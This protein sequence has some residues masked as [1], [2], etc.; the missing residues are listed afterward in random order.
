ME[1]DERGLATHSWI[2]SNE[3]LN[4]ILAEIII[5]RIGNTRQL[6]CR[7]QKHQIRMFVE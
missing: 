6:N 4:D 5:E 1:G 2:C 7:I 3:Q